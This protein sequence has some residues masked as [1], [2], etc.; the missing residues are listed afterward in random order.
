MSFLRG[1]D[2]NGAGVARP[3][4]FDFQ[5]VTEKLST[6][7]DLTLRLANVFQ[8]A[9]AYHIRIALAGFALLGGAQGTTRWRIQ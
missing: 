2:S 5:R 1:K 4:L 9:L 3:H 6:L 7:V 8:S